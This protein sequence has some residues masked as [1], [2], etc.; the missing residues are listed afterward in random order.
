MIPVG[1]GKGTAG[2]VAASRAGEASSP[3]A[4]CCFDSRGAKHAGP[5][6]NAQ[7]GGT[8]EKFSLSF[9]SLS[10]SHTS[11]CVVA[12]TVDNIVT[13]AVRVFRFFP[14]HGCTG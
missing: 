8:V 12:K 9:P 5:R 7:N 2:P 14:P 11:L 13:L 4:G 6:F 10:Y 3:R 1:G